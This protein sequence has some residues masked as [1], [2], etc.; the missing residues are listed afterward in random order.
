MLLIEQVQGLAW[1]GLAC[2]ALPCH[3][4]DMPVSLK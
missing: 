3:D 2:P 4:H 1:P